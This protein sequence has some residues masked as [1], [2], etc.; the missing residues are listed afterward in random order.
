MLFASSWPPN[1]TASKIICM[2]KPRATPMSDL[3]HGDDEA[4][5]RERRDAGG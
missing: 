1:A 4:R 2:Q 5:S 3:L